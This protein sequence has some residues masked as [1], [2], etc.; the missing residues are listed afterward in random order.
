MN[1]ILTP[2]QI[3]QVHEYSLE[4]LEKVG[5]SVKCEEALDILGHAGCDVREPTRVK[6][7]R[8]L[9]AEAIEKAPKRIEV[10]NRLGNLAM[11]FEKDSCYYGTGSD[12]PNTIDLYSGVRRASTKEDIG[13][14][15]KFCDALPNIDFVMSFGIAQ[16]VSTGSD[17]VH[18]YEA[19]LLN[20]TKPAIVTGHGRK[21]MLAMIEMAAAAR[22]SMDEITS[23]PCLVLYTEPVSPLIHTEMGVGKGLVCC[24]YNIPFI[25]I[26][27]PMMGASGPATLEGT[28]VQAV[29]ESLSGLVIFQNKKP[30]AKFIFGGDC[31]ILDMSDLIFSYGC[32][33]L[34]IHNMA[35]ADMAHFYKLPFFCIAGSTD[36]KTLDA[37]AGMEYAFSIYNATLN[38][39]NIIH[40]CGY[41]ES[42]LTSSFE[43]VLF[44]D[45]IIS[46]VKRFLNL[47]SFN[48]NRVPI[49]IMDR[50]GPGGNFLK[51]KHTKENY[52]DNWVPRYLDRKSFE[53]WSQDGSKDIKQ[54]L[55]IKAKQIFESHQT[56]PIADDIL[57]QISG[58][59]N[60]HHPDVI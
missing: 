52:K 36:S 2:E 4:L 50:V 25:Y 23:K 40:D 24:E 37:Q 21:D 20:T 51:E 57:K 10:F 38:G 31:T 59:V 22:G 26:A 27:S 49:A 53:R 43:S 48:E 55:N 13:R 41:L 33:E 47:L 14:L 54:A 1:R 42:G 16:D 58:I 19:M 5:C 30:G 28:L 45:E 34:N 18:G 32:P 9:V 11:T 17:F 3:N 56:H 44:A 29:A 12:C 15:A 35:L 60:K 39:C 8:K 7:P 6:I 46:M